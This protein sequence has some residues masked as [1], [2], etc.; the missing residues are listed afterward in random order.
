MCLPLCSIHYRVVGQVLVITDCLI[1]VGIQFGSLHRS[2][3]QTGRVRCFLLALAFMHTTPNIIHNDWDGK[4][5]QLTSTGNTDVFQ[6]LS[7]CAGKVLV[8]DLHFPVLSP[9]AHWALPLSLPLNTQT[10]EL[11]LVWGLY[12]LPS[13]KIT[14]A[15]LGR[16]SFSI[17]WF[18]NMLVYSEVIVLFSISLF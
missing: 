1:Y 17:S 2:R 15:F 11:H 14:V 18:V 9:R 4:A 5:M 12:V 10:T 16:P 3:S 13:S 6:P 8:L 7:L